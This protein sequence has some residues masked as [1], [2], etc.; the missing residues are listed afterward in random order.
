M[1]ILV[2]A[3]LHLSDKLRDSYRFQAMKIITGIVKDKSVNE[4]YL[5]GDLTEEKDHHSAE[6]VNQVVECVYQ[7][8][9]LVEGIVI[10]RG[11]HDYTSIDCPFF[12]FLSRLDRVSWI[13]KPMGVGR[14]LFLPHTTQYK[15]DWKGLD[16]KG[17]DWVFAHQT[18]NGAAVGFGRELEGIPLTVFPRGVQVISG[19][20]HVPQK[21]G[22]VTYVG[23]P[24]QVDFGDDYSPRVLLLTGQ[25]I[26]SIPVPG[27][28]KRLVEVGS[29]DQLDKF[30]GLS[31]G[32]ILKVRV[33]I[34]QR[35]KAKWS[36]IRESIL[37]WGE[38]HGYVIHAIQPVVQ[39][40]QA[41][42]V[43]IRSDRRSDRKVLTDFAQQNGVDERTVKTGL[44][45]LEVV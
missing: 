35:Q 45:L 12:G 39:Q 8:S 40:E 5:L 2:V 26:K 20:I 13:N 34:T 22:C 30:T 15:R 43:Q 6:L 21:L 29:I 33:S 19:D 4:I 27:A 38:K 41:Q 37:G 23:A 42:G 16:F 17:Y 11:N 18:F 10:I 14:Y 3:D 32:D 36:A 1:S 7:F 28:Q 24:Y 44:S 31:S 9:Q 25:G